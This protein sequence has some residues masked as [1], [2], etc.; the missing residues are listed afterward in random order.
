MRGYSALLMEFVKLILCFA[1][2]RYFRARIEVIWIMFAMQKQALLVAADNDN[3][4]NK[5]PEKSPK[6]NPVIRQNLLPMCCYNEEVAALGLS[7]ETCAELGIGYLSYGRSALR[8]RVIMQL[9]DAR[10]KNEEVDYKQVVLSHIGLPNEEHETHWIYPGFNAELDLLG[11]ERFRLDKTTQQQIFE[12]KTIILTDDPLGS[13]KAYQ[14][15]IQNIVSTLGAS[16]SKT[17]VARLIRMAS[18]FKIDRIILM[19]HRGNSTEAK[20]LAKLETLF[21]TFKWEQSFKSKTKE[22]FGIPVNITSLSELSEKQILWLRK[23]AL[24]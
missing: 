11:Q 10:Q 15:G 7:K 4:D 18:E 6:P 13:A 24:L 5:T 8:G 12:S 23:K 2:V 21:E 22:R 16:P 17:Q 20:K 19:F 9:R 14:C 3:F 1:Q